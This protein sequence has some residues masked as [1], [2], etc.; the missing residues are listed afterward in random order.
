MKMT[1]RWR[2]LTAT[3][4]LTAALACFVS[5]KCQAQNYL[6]TS[7]SKIVDSSGNVVRL[8]GLNW[9]GLETGNY[10]PHGLWTRSMSS[11]LDQIKS[12]GYN[13]LRVPYC[14]QLFDSGSAPN[15]IDYTKNPDLVGLSG[16]QIL[17]KLVAGCKSRGIKIFLD[18]HRPDSGAQ[19]PLWY[20]SGEY[21]EARWISDWQMLA[22]RYAGNDTVIGCDLHNEPHA[23]A[24]WGT[25]DTS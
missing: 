23:P 13:C 19:S 3:A 24:T 11:Y 14:T 21:T 10:S 22:A 25:G 15:S 2:W 16:I 7:G 20:T 5:Q 1:H 12:L 6:H 9:F 18:R 8:T 17:D 4:A